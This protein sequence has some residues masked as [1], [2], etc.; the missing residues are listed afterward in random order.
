MHQHKPYPEDFW[1]YL[2]PQQRDLIIEGQYLKDQI[3]HDAEYSF[4]DYSFLV[5]PF[6]KAYEGYLKQVFL[7]RKMITHLDYINDHFRIGKR[8]SPHM[9][10]RLG[11]HKSLYIQ[12]ENAVSK[13]CAR[14]VWQTWKIHRNELFHY[15][16]HNYKAITFAEANEIVTEI[17]GTMIM[18]YQSLN[19][20]EKGSFE[21]RHHA[22]NAGQ[23]SRDDSSCH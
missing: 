4:K 20:V 2:T 8:L 23:K 1:N 10:E 17:I 12:L 19:L 15:F 18:L 14:R 9:M 5:F 3:I 6:A 13:E 7:D 16:P 22:H 21:S 11:P